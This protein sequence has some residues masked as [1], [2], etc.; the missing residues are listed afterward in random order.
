MIDQEESVSGPRK[1]KRRYKTKRA[2]VM[3]KTSGEVVGSGSMSGSSSILE[4]SVGSGVG[5]DLQT[6]GHGV[7]P[8]GDTIA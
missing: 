3:S 6:A 2:L 5:T 1:A 4:S 8:M 7:T